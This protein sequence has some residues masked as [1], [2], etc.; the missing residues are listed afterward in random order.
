MFERTRV[1]KEWFEKEGTLAFYEQIKGDCILTPEA[2]K[3]AF[4]CLPCFGI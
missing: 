2:A 1:Q 4:F 3:T